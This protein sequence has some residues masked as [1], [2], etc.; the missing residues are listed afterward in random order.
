MKLPPFNH[1]KMEWDGWRAF[2]VEHGHMYGTFIQF[3][4]GEFVV[5]RHHWRPEQRIVLKDLH[6]QITATG[7]KDCPRLYVP[8]QTKS[9]PKSHLDHKG[10]QVLLLDFDHKRAVSLE[11]TLDKDNAPSSIP[12]RFLDNNSRDITAYYAGPKAIPLG[13]PIVRHFPQP[14]SRDQRNHLNELT[15]AAKVW[16][17]MQ[18]DPAGLLKKHRDQKWKAPVCLPAIE[19]VDVSFGVLTTEHRV[20]LA[21]DGFDMIVRQEHPWLTF[22]VE[23]EWTNDEADD[24]C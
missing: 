7:D 23:G 10:M 15:E 8:G 18:P 5:C 24:D 9:I 21:A 17:Q 6:I 12:T 16:L 20:A 2:H 14:L 13:T 4:T 11:H 3:D 19:F 1:S 22:N